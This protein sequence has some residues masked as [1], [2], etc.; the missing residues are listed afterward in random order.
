MLLWGEPEGELQVSRLVCRHQLCSACWEGHAAVVSGLWFAITA[1]GPCLWPFAVTFFA[2]QQSLRHLPRPIPC[3]ILHHPQ[4]AS[5][6]ITAHARSA[7]NCRSCALKPRASK[8]SAHLLP[9]HPFAPHL[10]GRAKAEKKKKKNLPKSCSKLPPLSG[11]P[12][13]RR[14]RATRRRKAQRLLAASQ[15]V[16]CRTRVWGW[17][18]WGSADRARARRAPGGPGET[19]ALQWR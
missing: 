13:G 11:A 9:P 14:H 18:P 1:T 10:P 19:L 7:L 3:M 17:A 2:A 15:L 6:T 16:S 4:V 12:P 5:S 8:L